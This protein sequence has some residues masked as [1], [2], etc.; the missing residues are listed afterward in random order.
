VTTRGCPFHCTFCSSWTVH[1]REMRYRSTEN[2]VK[3]LRLLRDRYHVTTL[4]PEDDLFSVKKPRFLE[5]CHAVAEEFKGEL[6]FQFPNGLSVATLDPEVIAAMIRMGMSVAN[7]AIE[8]GS[9][10]IQR[11]VIKKNLDLDRARGVVKTCRDQG[12]IVRAYFILGFPGETREQ[13]QET[14]DF[15]GSLES[16][17]TIIHPAAPLI[18]TEMFEQLLQRGE[19]DQSFNWDEAF[20]HERT[21]DTPEIGA[22]DLKDLAYSANLRLNFFENYNLRCGHYERA[23]NLYRDILRVYPD[24]LAAHCCLATALRLAGRHDEAER[25][26]EAAR[27]LIE[28][29]SPMALEQLARFPE[30]FPWCSSPRAPLASVPGPRPGMPTAARQPI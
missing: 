7:I 14:I 24:H 10:E 12:I 1:G 28:R 23:A 20:F 3:E 22:E 17:W 19:I 26:F 9:H 30:F 25:A 6:H 11:N 15:A 18:G 2:V 27:D 21:Y 29:Q 4:I 8:S 5:L 13:M 16:D